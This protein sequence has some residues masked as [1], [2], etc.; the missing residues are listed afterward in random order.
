MPSQKEDAS[1]GEHEVSQNFWGR[2]LVPGER[3]F[4]LS[5]TRTELHLTSASVTAAEGAAVL[6][7]SSS[8]I[9]DIPICSLSTKGPR[10][11]LLDV[12][13]FE[14]DESMTLRVEGT[15]PINIA[16][17]VAI[18][19]PPL[20][21]SED[22]EA[23]QPQ[24]IKHAAKKQA[25][26]VAPAGKASSA[27]AEPREEEGDD[28]EGA[29]EEAGEDAGAAPEKAPSAAERLVSAK[30]KREAEPPAG[31]QPEAHV[32]KHAKEEGRKERGS[33][34]SEEAGVRGAPDPNA[35]KSLAGGKLKYR[36]IVVGSGAVPSA[37]KHV[38]VH[39]TGRLKSG[40]VFDSDKG[41]GFKFKIGTGAVIKGWDV[42]VA[43]MAVGGKRLLVIHPDLAYGAHGAPPTIPPHATLLF[44]VELVKV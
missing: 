26:R 23:E 43:G 4:T 20:P 27:P 29:D 13:F 6:I 36:D 9:K 17:S 28:K 34:P 14:G 25:L 33:V 16:G 12:N 21:D 42:G 10:Q 19:G 38:S 31:A 2:V 30:R 11:C 44:D 1:A 3:P 32:A 39:Y 7:A 5:L 22:E 15:C 41:A 40:K 8:I 35:L 37:G 18:F 24:R